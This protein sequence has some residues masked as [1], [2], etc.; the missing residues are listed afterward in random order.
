MR[1]HVI[2]LVLFTLIQPQ[3]PRPLTFPFPISTN[4]YYSHD[5][6]GISKSARACKSILAARGHSSILKYLGDSSQGLTRLEPSSPGVPRAEHARAGSCPTLRVALPRRASLC[7][8]A[9]LQVAQPHRLSPAAWQARQ[10]RHL[11]RRNSLPE[12]YR[13]SPRGESI[14]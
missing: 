11:G 8:M 12:V 1:S 14:P 9:L 4:T 2:R 7:Q 13:R 10:A 6:K 3:L 5:L